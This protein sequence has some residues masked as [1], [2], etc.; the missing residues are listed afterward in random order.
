MNNV[1]V[2]EVLCLRPEDDF[3]RVGVVPPAELD[4]SFVSP[5][6]RSIPSRLGRASAV[7]IPAVGTPLPA[8]WFEGGSIRLAQFT[9]AGVDRLDEAA[10]KALGIPVANVPGG[11]NSALAEYALACALMLLRRI[12]WA[13]R[14]V[15]RGEYSAARAR[16]LATNLTG[17]EGLTVGVVGLGNIGKAV[18]GAFK[19]MGGQIVYCDPGVVDPAGAA[20]LGARPLPLFELLA[21]A[22]VVTLH[23]PLAAA[24]RNMIGA[25]EL[26]VMKR[27]AVLIN[28][29]RGGV[30]DERALADALS[31][32]E[33]AAAAV[34]VY[35]EEPP[36]ETHPLLALQGDA[37]ER[38]IL[39]PHIAGV[40]RQASANLF[41][42]A[43]DN[44]V[45]VIVRGEPPRNRVY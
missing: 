32:G 35:A 34:D 12:H 25:S 5:N 8:A 27:T 36:G 29:A 44:V 4:I 13:D 24:T 39:T 1:A 19:R 21:E 20:E 33:I 23:V 30:V 17:L 3:L 26:A 45:R 16:M 14:Q 41:A 40:T 42:S 7:V 18:A 11:S 9:G 31:R 15:R 6:D 28:A 37:A 43:W 38:L 2:P 10:M 22:D